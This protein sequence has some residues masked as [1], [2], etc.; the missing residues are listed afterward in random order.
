MLS[1][2]S[3]NDSQSQDFTLLENLNLIDGTGAKLQAGKSILIAGDTIHQILDSHESIDIENVV[4]VDLSGKYLLPGLFDMHVHFATAPS[5]NDNLERTKVRLSKFLRQGV[6]GVRDMAGDTRQLAFLARQAALDEIESPDIYY[7]ALMAGAFFFDDPRTA[8]SAK[9]EVPGAT[10]WMKAIT[11]DTDIELAVA[12]AKGT[13]ATGIKIYADLP[14]HLS[15]KVILEARKQDFLVWAHASVIPTMPSDLVN[16]GIHSVSHSPLLAWETAD[17]KPENG[18]QRYN[19]TDL[20][21]KRPEFKAL[22]QSMAVREIFLDPTVKI[23]KGRTVIYNNG[24]MAT[25][26]AYKAGVPLVLGTDMSLGRQDIVNFPIIDE[27]HTWV[28]AV[29]IPPLEVIKAATYNA[30]QLLK[31]GD[32]AGTISVGQKANLLIV[33]D[34]PLEDMKHLMNVYSVYKNGKRVAK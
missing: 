1:I 19:E 16:A 15:A 27:M 20:D 17:K 11:D 5:G 29:G 33:D 26:A 6:T 23:Y 13:G 25:L 30:A 10:A 21:P 14:A 2:F 9:G 12:Q 7:S 8:A 18:K 24:I 28:E 31:L 4:R 3:I 34:N 22:L 32:K